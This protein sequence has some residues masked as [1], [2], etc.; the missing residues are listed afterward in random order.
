MGHEFRATDLC[1]F[2]GAAP[3][4]QN[5]LNGW[6]IDL[7]DA[8][9]CMI[10][11]INAGYG[12]GLRH[13]MGANGLRWRAATAG[14]N[15][16][17]SLI[18]EVS[19]K[20]ASP[21]TAAVLIDGHAAD[22]NKVINNILMSRIQVNAPSGG[23]GITPLPGT[24][25]IKLWNAARI[26][27]I[28]CD[29]EVVETAFEEYSTV[30]S[31][32][33]SCV[34]NTYLG[35][36]THYC[37]EAYKDSNSE[38]SRSV[39]QRNF[40]GCDN[41]G[42]AKMGSYS[43]DGG[44]AQD[45][46]AFL[47]G[48]WLMSLFSEPAIQFRSRDKGVLLLT[49]DYKGNFQTDADGHPSTQKPYRG[50]LIELSSKN[51]TKITRTVS[52]D[53]ADPDL[54]DG[55]NLRDTRLEL[56]NGEDDFRGELARV[57]INDPL[58]LRPR[59]TEPPRPID[60]LIYY[61]ATAGAVPPTGDY[62]LGEGI[63]S[64]LKNGIIAPLAVEPGAVSMLERNLD[65]SVSASDFG[66]IHRV[67]N[68]SDRTVTIESGLLEPGAGARRLW[69]I[70]QGSGGVHFEVGD[71]V[72][73]H[74]TQNRNWIAH[75]RQMVEV[76]VTDDNDVFLNHIKPDVDE[77]FEQPL[78][79]TSGNLTV[80]NHYLGKLLRV[81]RNEPAYLE[82]PTGLVPQHMDA[83]S[84]RAMKMSGGDVEIRPGAGMTLI[85]PS[86]SS[87]FVITQTGQIITV[88]VSGPNAPQQP[89]HIYIDD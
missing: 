1:F 32:S 40:I 72:T 42:P 83:A 15:Y 59:T 82:V 36:I 31:G 44:R 28:D 21:N 22:N 67:N 46:D 75:Q 7:V 81:S 19:I 14:V 24:N 10:S 85:S 8:N 9:E 63:Y 87:T 35:C 23:G 66:K 5:D 84:F 41:V 53:D 18:E 16:G 54:D 78:H 65:F 76:L 12:G 60:G 34:A 11:R 47:N 38:T 70:R 62:W 3:L 58:Y 48:V 13:R 80:P 6:C 20:L 86:G 77:P 50:L 37:P 79:W 29:V 57:Q 55:T 88:I 52:N 27:L 45:G 56:G 73:L 51:S 68:G 17:D 61:A 2:G 71:G 4:G 74:A 89:N 30:M 25:G 43:G 69:I 26:Q 39:Y 64:R 33:G 49:S